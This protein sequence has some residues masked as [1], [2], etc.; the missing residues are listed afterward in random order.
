VKHRRRQK[1]QRC[2]PQRRVTT[3]HRIRLTPARL[4]RI[5]PDP[6]EYPQAVVEVRFCRDT[7]RLCDSIR[8]CGWDLRHG[9]GESAG[10]VKSFGRTGSGRQSMLRGRVVAQMW[11][12]VRALQHRPSEITSHE[13]GHAAMAWARWRG[14]NLGVMPGEEVMCYALGRLVA[15]LNRVCYAS[16][17]F[18]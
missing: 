7:R 5:Y 14:A 18:K 8:Q 13:C 3:I 6:D 2:R 9:D 12:S 11:L 15:Q 16:G 17:A 4:F 10:L 1:P